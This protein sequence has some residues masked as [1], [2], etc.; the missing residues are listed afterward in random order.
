MAV[1]Y[2]GKYYE[3]VTDGSAEVGDFI[4]V[5]KLKGRPCDIFCFAQDASEA[6][7]LV[8]AL[9]PGGS[10][11][12]DE[13]TDLFARY[14]EVQTPV[15]KAETPPKPYETGRYKVASID[16]NTGL[17]VNSVG[18]DYV[19]LTKNIAVSADLKAESSA[20]QQAEI[21]NTYGIGTFSIYKEVASLVRLEDDNA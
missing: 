6:M 13:D 3:L 7:P 14:R 11:I 1:E 17:Y 8:D 2:E 4:H 12:L 5:I 20:Q 18:D 15:E 10:S 16:G 9:L 19:M 21:A